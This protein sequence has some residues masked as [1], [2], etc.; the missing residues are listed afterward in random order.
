MSTDVD[1][2]DMS[3]DDLEAAFRAA[4]AEEQSPEDD[5][6]VAAAQQQEED[7]DDTQEGEEDF[8]DSDEEGSDDNEEDNDDDSEDDPDEDDTEEDSDTDDDDEGSEEDDTTEDDD[9]SDEESDEPDDKDKN[10]EQ[11]Y[12]F[13][14]NGQE[15]NFT[16][17]EIK[18]Q[19]PKVFGQAMDYTKKMQAIKP[20]RRTIDAM[21]NADIKHDDINLM[22]DVFKGDK[23]AIAEV[24][25]RTGV[26][27][28]DINVDEESKYVAKEY[29]RAEEVLDLSEVIESIQG[30]TE[31]SITHDI[32][33]KRWDDSSWNTLS[34]DPSK[35]KALHTDVKSGLYDKVQPIAAK[36]KVFDGGKKSDLDYYLEAGNQYYSTLENEAISQR[37][38]VLSAKAKD[39]SKQKRIADVKTQ[40]KKRDTTKKAAGKRKA[41]APSARTATQRG[42]TI[43]YL[44][45]SDEEFEEWYKALEDKS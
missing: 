41:A 22:I 29:G 38:R 30:D 24:L 10:A 15:Y 7:A 13:R 42:G 4:K 12:Q 23:D 27:A 18:T 31:Y 1:L 45:A 35:V 20:W 11:T 33:A 6:E 21:E 8:D 25:K 32:L 34:R 44:N 37:E 3:D 16:E 14:A 43:D 9:P 5:L 40:E 19:F 17:E 36:L 2:H 39:A 26:D 28:L